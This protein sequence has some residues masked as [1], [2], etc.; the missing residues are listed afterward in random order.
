MAKQLNVNLAFTADTSKAKAQLQELQ[1]TLKNFATNASL[2]TSGLGLT[3]ELQDAANAASELQIKLQQSTTSTGSLDLG[4]FNQSLKSSG[5]QLSDYANQL[6]NLGPEG[7]QAFSQLARSITLAEV[8]LKRSSKLL[9]EFATTM[10]NTVR[11]QLTS[12]MLHS[13]MGAMSSA[14]GYAQ[15]LNESLNN[16]R[17]VT[18][19]NTEQMAKFANEANKAAKALSTTTTAYTDAALIYYQQGLDDNQVKER[20]DITIKMANVSRQSAEEVSDQLTA[21]WNNF[22]KGGESLEHFA[23]VMTR[24]GADTASSSDEIAQGLE[25]FSAVADMI[26]LSF[27]NAA[28]ALATVT[29]TTRQSAD[30][31]G[32][33]FKTIFARIQGLSLGETLDDGTNLN[34]YSKAL[35]AVGINIK[36]QNGEL[37]DMD[38]ILAEM[39]AKWKMLSKDQQVALAQTVAGVRQYN[40]LIALMDNFDFYQKNLLAAQNSTGTLQEQADI[41]AESWEAARDRVKA[42]LQGIYGDVLDDD[43]FI[44]ILNDFSG[45]L[46][47]VNLFIDAIGGLKGLL[48]LIS[49]LL[50]KA[51][52]DDLAN[53]INRVFYNIKLG[54]EKGRKEIYDLRKEAAQSLR[55]MYDD[56]TASGSAMVDVG[57]KQADLQNILLDK[58]LQLQSANKSLTEEE[59]KQAQQ[60]L[61]INSSLSDQYGQ[62]VKNREKSQEVSD[63]LILKAKQKGGNKLKD[64]DITD[65]SGRSFKGKDGFAEAAKQAGNLQNTYK[66]GQKIIKSYG[67]AIDNLGDIVDINSDEFK[68]LQTRLIE[69]GKAADASGDIISQDLNEQLQALATAAANGDIK[70]IQA[71]MEEISIISEKAGDDAYDMFVLIEQGAQNAGVNMKTFKPILDQIQDE[72]E[73]TGALSADAIQLFANLGFQV[74]ESGRIISSFKGKIASVGDA[75]AATASA[76]STYGMALSQASA[77]GENLFD[78]DTKPLEKL[79][80]LMILGTT[81][82]Q[83]YNAVNKAGKTIEEAITAAKVRK[84]AAQAA[85]AATATAERVAT[86]LN[87]AAVNKNKIAWLSH[88]ILGVIAIALMAVV[89]VISAVSARLEAN[90]EKLKENAEASKEAADATYEEAKANEELFDSFEK[91]LAEYED[92]IGSKEDLEAATKAL[93]EAYDIENTKLIEARG[94]YKE[95][96]RAIKE[97]EQAKLDQAITD[98]KSAITHNEEAFKDTMRDGK[99]RFSGDDYIVDFGGISNASYADDQTIR[100][101]VSNLQQDGKLKSNFDDNSEFSDKLTLTTG[102]TPAEMI[103]AYE[104]VQAIILET[105]RIA[106][107]KG[108]ET[109]LNDSEYWNQMN[110]WLSKSKENY[111]NLVALQSQLQDL[112]VMSA[113]NEVA[114]N[115]GDIESMEEYLAM[116]KE[117]AET[118]A[119]NKD[120]GLSV[121]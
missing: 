88:P 2:K 5:K 57:T 17:I 8:P 52:G 115:Y 114:K 56:G 15:D 10:K 28:A 36:E 13:F 97:A 3:K 31:V 33:A 112:S 110:D 65:S 47:A 118:L 94:N 81:I 72:F 25:K 9:S 89:G 108:T 37:K 49:T 61:D 107:E 73:Q 21:V 50:F 98:A 38:S 90:S 60:L 86:D 83:T 40:Q 69:V 39:G 51:F 82:I 54:S 79:I 16:I 99:G 103:A 95:L 85:S 105:K 84:A 1:N 63:D 34:K 29:A 59:K 102:Q 121:E 119:S 4:K 22:A 78:P 23:D 11:W 35:E 7:Q 20:T 14:Y 62:L 113:T 46:D 100:D 58:T 106:Q 19:Q 30:V 27:D 18:G 75:V 96:T 77:F 32:T 111:D 42:S 120:L 44:G 80:S 66:Q 12:S 68:N 74:D 116:E 41:Y 93:C 67:K 53:S 71:A 6:K 117:L 92:G 101:A 55:D 24:L 76:V 64:F 26:G 43:V 87:T 91:A 45:L 109:E 48:P 104:D 70:G